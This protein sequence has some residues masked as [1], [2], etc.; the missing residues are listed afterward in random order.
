MTADGVIVKEPFNTVA[1]L[2]KRNLYK[3]FKE[4]IYY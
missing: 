4:S 3:S 2:D 1:D